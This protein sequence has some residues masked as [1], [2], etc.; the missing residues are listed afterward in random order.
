MREKG[1]PKEHAKRYVASFRTWS[2]ATF[3]S[4]LSDSRSAEEKSKIVDEFYHRC[5]SLVAK[6]PEDHGFDF[7]E[8]YIVIRKRE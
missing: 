2:N 3:I 6:Q 1:D 7:V 4:G 5:E 8:A